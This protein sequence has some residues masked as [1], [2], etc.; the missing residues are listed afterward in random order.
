MAQSTIKK[1]AVI[2]ARPGDCN[3]TPEK[4]DYK[5]NEDH[6]EGVIPCQAVTYLPLTC[7]RPSAKRKTEE[8]R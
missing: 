7:C 3:R 6:D 1:L 8:R 2:P 4:I 5:E